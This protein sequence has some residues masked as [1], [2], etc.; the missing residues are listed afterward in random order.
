MAEIARSSPTPRR[1]VAGSARSL[2]LPA[3]RCLAHVGAYRPG[4]RPHATRLALAAGRGRPLRGRPRPP[5]RGTRLVAWRLRRLARGPR[6]VSTGPGASGPR[7]FCDNPAGRDRSTIDRNE[8]N[9]EV[10]AGTPTVVRSSASSF[11][12]PGVGAR[13]AKQ[14]RQ[15]RTQVL[16]MG[17]TPQR[18][19][20]AGRA[21]PRGAG[22]ARGGARPRRPA[23]TATAAGPAVPRVGSGS[24][25]SSPEGHGGDASASPAGGRGRLRKAR[26]SGRT[27]VD[28]E[29][30]TLSTRGTET[31]QY[32]EE[33]K[34]TATPSVAA[35][36]RGPA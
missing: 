27:H 17:A 25:W 26:G 14:A 1:R 34:A 23:T 16:R 13:I 18:A 12:S 32:P 28:P 21:A 22:P 30:P 19:S 24:A 11:P 7:A 33:R 4:D 36:E 8:I 15:E 2:A 29:M 35:S 9:R 20:R 31:S 10:D 5:V 3:D 6:L